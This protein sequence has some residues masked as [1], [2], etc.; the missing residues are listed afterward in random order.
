MFVPAAAA[1]TDGVAAGLVAAAAPPPAVGEGVAGA[2][3]EPLPRVARPAR[4][5]PA[6]PAAAMPAY[7]SSEPPVMNIGVVPGNI[8]ATWRTAGGNIQLCGTE[9]PP[10]LV[11]FPESA[12]VGGW[13][14]VV[15]LPPPGVEGRGLPGMTESGPP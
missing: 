8:A 11:E 14:G 3:E 13:G 2:G 4:L 15:S 6:K 7:P 1:G 12:T 9:S 10:I 5:V